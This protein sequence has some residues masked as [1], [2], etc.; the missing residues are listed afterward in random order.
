MIEN[1]TNLAE[2][3]INQEINTNMHIYLDFEYT[4]VMRRKT[5]HLNPADFFC[6]VFWKFILDLFW[7]Q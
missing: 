5:Y 4:I 6:Q 2:C 7:D 3:D 1:L